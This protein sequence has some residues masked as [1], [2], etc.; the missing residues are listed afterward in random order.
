MFVMITCFH[1]HNLHN[2]HTVDDDNDD[3]D[4]DDEQA[5]GLSERYIEE[6]LR[7]AALHGYLQFCQSV[8]FHHHH[9]YHYVHHHLH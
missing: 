9:H 2:P 8:S 1:P 7:A 3:D 5:R 4:D 6:I